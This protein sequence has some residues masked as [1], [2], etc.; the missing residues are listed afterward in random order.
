MANK[1]VSPEAVTQLI[2]YFTGSNGDQLPVPIKQET[3]EDMLDGRECANFGEYSC[4]DDIN[5]ILD[6]IS[7][8][9]D[10]DDL[11]DGAIILFVKNSRCELDLTD[12]QFIGEVA[13]EVSDEVD[14]I[15]GIC[16]QELPR[17]ENMRVRIARFFD[18]RPEW[19]DDV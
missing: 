6:H 9:T 18:E 11:A 4:E 19:M 15:W 10:A 13:Q 2:N 14:L 7:D 1:R 3:I 16:S 12:M 5:D 17:K 8:E